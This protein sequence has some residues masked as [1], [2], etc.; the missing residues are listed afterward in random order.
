MGSQHTGCAKG[1]GTNLH[2]F[3]TYVRSVSEHFIVLDSVANLRKGTGSFVM[4]VCLSVFQREEV[5]LLGGLSCDFCELKSVG[6]FRFGLNVTNNR[7]FT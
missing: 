2:K 1:C 5:F 3:T 7:R 6:E 4:S